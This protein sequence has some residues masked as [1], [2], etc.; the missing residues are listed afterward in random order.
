MKTPSFRYIG[1]KARLR[2][3]LISHFPQTGG[4]YVELFVGRANVF[5][6][7]KRQLSFKRWHLNDL[8]SAF[9]QALL[10]ADLTQLPDHVSKETFNFWKN[11]NSAVSAIIEPRITFAGKGYWAGFSGTSGTHVGYSGSLYRQVCESARSLLSGC[12]ITSQ[13][14]DQVDLSGLGKDDFVYLD[15]PYYGTTNTTYPNIDH[16][17]LVDFLNAAP[18]RWAMSG[19]DNCLYKSSLRFASRYERMRN[20][21]I[22]SSN[23]GHKEPVC[24]VL[25]MN[26]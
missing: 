26:Y 8:N 21:E 18:F 19:Y 7:A 1:G 12:E 24:E 22:K 17:K 23:S 4:S 9:L 14:W 13:S 5:F 15:P 20:S 11:Q 3:W 6:E 10:D 2:K 25:W 16:E